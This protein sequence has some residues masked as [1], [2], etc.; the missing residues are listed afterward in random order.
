MMIGPCAT[1]VSRESLQPRKGG[2]AMAA[3]GM[4]ITHAMVGVGVV[5]DR[6]IELFPRTIIELQTLT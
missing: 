5:G 6:Q 1:F 3:E 2:C 4:E